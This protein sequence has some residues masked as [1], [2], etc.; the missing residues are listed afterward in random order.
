MRISDLS[1]SVPTGPMEVMQPDV[2]A[3]LQGVQYNTRNSNS[4]RGLMTLGLAGAVAVTGLVACSNESDY[5]GSKN[6][7]TEVSLP[8]Q[9]E[10]F[11]EAEPLELNQYQ[12]VIKNYATE[13]MPTIGKND[14]NAMR[15]E[16]AEQIPQ[17][18]FGVA[19]IKA[20]LDQNTQTLSV[21]NLKASI[22]TEVSNLFSDADVRDEA[23]QTVV[24]EFL[25]KGERVVPTAAEYFEVGPVYENG[26]L[27][28]SNISFQKVN[29]FANP[30]TTIDQELLGFFVPSPDGRMQ[31]FLT[32]EGRLLIPVTAGDEN[33]TTN[34]DPNSPTEELSFTTKEGNE[35]TVTTMPNGD[36]KV[37]TTTPEGKVTEKV[38]TI[39]NLGGGTGPAAGN[40]GEPN[41]K[42]P[43]GD[44]PECDA[45]AEGDCKGPAGGVTPENPGPGPGPEGPGPEGPGPEGP[46][47]TTTTQK[48]T[49]TTTQ[50]PTTTTTTPKGSV[51]TIPGSPR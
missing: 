4:W 5:N 33:G 37:T 41:G 42:G 6:D 35:V 16:F 13:A 46:G 24:S 29:P 44:G 20:L 25:T 51:I 27:D 1:G 38:T 14:V 9:Q 43:G 48:P 17:N 2:T 21:A 45:N 47:T 22:Q 3:E 49:T 7:G 28:T 39:A 10:Q 18:V 26:N 8:E 31:A 34:F 15:S 11:C 32:K 50:K 40:Q 36:K 23:C 30:E 19:A 12:E